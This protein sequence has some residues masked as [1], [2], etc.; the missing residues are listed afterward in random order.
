[1]IVLPLS[2]GMVALIDEEDA[3]LSAFKWSAGKRGGR[4]YAFRMDPETREPIYLHHAL[5]PDC[6][7]GFVRDHENGCSLDNRRGNL[8]VIT[9]GDNLRN[10][11]KSKGVSGKRGKWRA[12]INTPE[13]KYKHL[14][15][16]STEREA[17]VARLRAEIEIFGGHPAREELYRE[18]GLR[19]C[20]EEPSL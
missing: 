11:G 19:A 2:Q 12:Y 8:R 7:E 13:V 6:P 10:V 9:H 3:P 17:I 5:I 15:T 14:G 4:F 16:F 18:Y 1:M 20:G